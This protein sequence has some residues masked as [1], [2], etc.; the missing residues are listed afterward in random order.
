M[1]EQTPLIYTTLGN[2]PVSDLDYTTAWEVN[3]DYIKFCETYALNGEI[4]KQSAHIYDRKGAFGQAIA[5]Q[6]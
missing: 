6:L 2:V 3:N 4:V 5:A 1:T